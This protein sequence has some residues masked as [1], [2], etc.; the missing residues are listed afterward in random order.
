M[1]S[2]SGIGVRISPSGELS[3]RPG[4]R[5]KSWESSGIDTMTW[6]ILFFPLDR[7][8]IGA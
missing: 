1:D 5:I 2:V 4:R 8:G 6:E 7:S 3:S